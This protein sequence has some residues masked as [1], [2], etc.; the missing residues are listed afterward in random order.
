MTRLDSAMMISFCVWQPVEASAG[1]LVF[2]VF[3]SGFF[4]QVTPP[5]PSKPLAIPVAVQKISFV[6]T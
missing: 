4:G 6:I 5:L 3:N 2:P 1:G